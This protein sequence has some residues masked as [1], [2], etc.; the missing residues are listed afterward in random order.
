MHE[1]CHFYQHR[2]ESEGIFAA[3]NVL[4]K[5][6]MENYVSA[7]NVLLKCSGRALALKKVA[8]FL[9]YC[10]NELQTGQLNT[11]YLVSLLYTMQ[12]IP[13]IADDDLLCDDERERRGVW[14]SFSSTVP[15][16]LPDEEQLFDAFK[17][18]PLQ[19]DG[20]TSQYAI[21]DPMFFSLI[22]GNTDVIILLCEVFHV[23]LLSNEVTRQPLVNNTTRGPNTERALIN[24]IPFAQRW[25]LCKAPL[26]LD[27]NLVCARV[28]T[29]RVESVQRVSER[30]ILSGI[31]LLFLEA[32]L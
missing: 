2:S 22:A 12:L 28:F 6:T 4:P 16:Y 23:K 32:V 26:D 24:M 18:I 13:V 7:L 14:V 10:S 20:S 29:L 17:N 21:V 8:E 25:L 30:L 9:S 15:L 5:P 31:S 11:E 1:L 27:F 19:V 3:L